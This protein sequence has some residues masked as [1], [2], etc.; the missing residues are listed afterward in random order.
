M[1]RI[2]LIS[3]EHEE[4]KVWQYSLQ[5]RGY[6]T[7]LIASPSEAITSVR[8][9]AYRLIIIDA[10]SLLAIMIPVVKQLRTYTTAPILLM[11]LERDIPYVVS[12]FEAGAD[13]TLIKPV[14]LRLFLT[15]VR[16][17]IYRSGTGI[18]ESSAAQK[19]RDLQLNP[20][21]QIFI[22]GD[23]PIK[24]TPLEYR[25]LNLLMHHRGQTLSKDLL[26]SRVWGYT[27]DADANLLKYVIYR[28]RRK[29]EPDPKHP[30]YI[31]TVSG[32]GYVFDDTQRV[33]QSA[34]SGEF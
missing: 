29:I 28:L 24:L 4:G 23:K 11:I 33:L 8:E 9:A 18:T 22:V 21:E 2:L 15:K 32:E 16:I 5:Q 12:A 25:V 7:Q 14:G 26:V 34:V 17:W 20:V 1:P 31:L 19:I 30:R 13:D 6:E 10:F 27:D 3:S